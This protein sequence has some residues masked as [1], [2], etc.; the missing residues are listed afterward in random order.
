MNSTGWDK[1]LTGRVIR[2]I[3]MRLCVVTQYTSCRDPCT[4]SVDR[5]VFV[6]EQAG[7][8]QAVAAVVA[9][10]QASRQAGSRTDQ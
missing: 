1:Q 7:S 5:Y 3:M 9:G 4:G 10:W 8:R 6:L 2:V